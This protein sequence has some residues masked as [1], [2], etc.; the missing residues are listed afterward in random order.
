VEV[1]NGYATQNA[2]VSGWPKKAFCKKISIE[3]ILKRA[4]RYRWVVPMQHNN[5]EKAVFPP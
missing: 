4:S 2:F 3:Y 1:R 5:Q